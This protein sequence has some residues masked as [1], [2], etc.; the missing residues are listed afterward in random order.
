MRDEQEEEE[1]QE[2]YNGGREGNENFQKMKIEVTQEKL[3]FLHT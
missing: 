2:E 1:K 3:L